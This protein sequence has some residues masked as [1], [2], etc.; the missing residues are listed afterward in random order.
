M[1]TPLRAIRL[2]CLQCSR[3]SDNI[4]HC[5]SGRRIISTLTNEVLEPRPLFPY[6][7]GH[8]PT[9]DSLKGYESQKV[10]RP[11]KAI[12]LRCLDCYPEG[13]GPKRCG[14]PNCALYFYRM[15]KNPNLKGKRGSGRPFQSE[16]APSRG[17]SAANAPVG[18]SEVAP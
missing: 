13:G 14:V 12:R 6:R 8:K 1:R 15:G 4:L 7:F 11:L 5:A 18:V 2:Y 9:E 3:T 10:W 16:S 17:L